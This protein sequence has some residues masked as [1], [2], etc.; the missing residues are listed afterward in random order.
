MSSRRPLARKIAVAAV[1]ILV[2]QLLLAIGLQVGFSKQIRPKLVMQML[3]DLDQLASLEHC[4][5]RPGPWVR[6]DGGWSVW[7]IDESGAVVGTDA[8]FSNITLPAKGDSFQVTEAET[9]TVV[10]GAHAEGCGGI[11]MAQTGDFPFVDELTGELARL[12]LSRIGVMILAAIAMVAATAVPLVR[13]IRD[14]SNR[15][16]VIVNDDLEGQVA[17]D[18]RDELGDLAD[19]FDLAART[20]R[21]R[22][23]SLEHRD[24]VMRKALADLAHDL[25]TPLATLKL[26]A[27]SLPP[28]EAATA[29]RTELTYLEGLTHNFEAVLE[30]GVEDDLEQ[31]QLDGLVE[32][33]ALRYQPLAADR[34]IDFNTSLPDAVPTVLA[35]SVS[36]ERAVGNLIHNALRWAS[37]NVVV[38]VWTDA[39]WVRIEV[40]DDGPG[41]GDAAK[42]AIERGKRGPDARGEGFGLGLAIAEAVARRFGGR[43]E[44]GDGD[45]G[46]TLAAVVLPVVT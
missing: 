4:E 37:A 12:L 13:R 10:Y 14:L 5:D 34:N 33:L 3:V 44:L 28:S 2:L 8:P 30:G 6:T 20:A 32:R 21:Q 18:A 45:D 1:V 39:E 38:V 19:A 26:S 29:I 27:S 9:L 17:L 42:Q 11:V 40:R 25:R 23:A 46:G 24:D 35:E 41:I 22:L 31:V 7:P 36:L 16:N 43:L 15:V